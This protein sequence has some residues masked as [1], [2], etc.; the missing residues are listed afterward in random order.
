M[1]G[2]MPGPGGL[3]GGK[4]SAYEYARRKLLDYISYAAAI[5]CTIREPDTIEVH[6]PEQQELLAAKWK[7]LNK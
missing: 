1:E 3:Y 2:K 4:L 7:E 5:G 6:T